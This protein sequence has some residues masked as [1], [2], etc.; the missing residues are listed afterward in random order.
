MTDTTHAD[1]PLLCRL[2]AVVHR[3]VIGW[4]CILGMVGVAV[5]QSLRR[6]GV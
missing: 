6:W 3:T 4:L 2:A 1:A 5:I